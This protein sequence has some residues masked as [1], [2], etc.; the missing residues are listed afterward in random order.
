MADKPVTR[1]EA[2]DPSGKPATRHEAVPAQAKPVTRHEM[3]QGPGS[4]ATRHEEVP[5]ALRRFQLPAE[6]TSRYVYEGDLSSAGAQ[7]DVVLCRDRSSGEQVA[8][9]IY[10]PEMTAALESD[11]LASLAEADRA[12]V[13]PFRLESNRHQVWEVQEYF[14]LGS[15]EDAVRARGGGAQ[16]DGF[17]REVL[18][19][20]ALS[21]DHI[22]SRNIVHRDLKPQNILIRSLSP[23]DT[24]LA[25]FGLA[26]LGAMSRAVRSVAGTAH[27]TSPE[28][29]VGR[30]NKAND[31]WGLGIIV[32]ELLTGRH[33]FSGPDGHYLSDNEVRAAFF[34]HSWSYADVTSHRWRL[35]LDGLFAPGEHRWSW[36]Q[37]DAWLRGESPIAVP[38]TASATPQSSRRS[39][40]Y[41]FAAGE[42]HTPQELASA[43]RDNFMLARDHISGVKASDLISWLHSTSV[44]TAAD[45]LLVA[46][47][48][49]TAS[50]G[51]AV[52]ELQF[53]LDPD[54]PPVYQG[55]VLS[56]EAL[57]E[58]AKEALSGDTT[59]ADWI[60]NLRDSA[61]LTVMGR[62]SDNPTMSHADEL[63]NEWWRE[64][65]EILWR[66]AWREAAIQPFVEAAR[67]R[68]EGVL[69]GAA[70]NT[71]TH[72]D[73]SARASKALAEMPGGDSNAPGVNAVTSL[74]ATT[75]S[76]TA[77]TDALAMFVVP[78]WSAQE[79]LRRA[80][81]KR[82]ADEQERQR[83]EHAQAAAQAQARARA[84]TKA[85]ERAAAN[86]EKYRWLLG[87]GLAAALIAVLAA[88]LNGG[89]PG[90]EPVVAEP[91]VSTAEASVDP[92]AG[93]SAPKY[94]Q[95]FPEL[96]EYT[97]GSDTVSYSVLSAQG[98]NDIVL[99]ISSGLRMV[100]AMDREKNVEAYPL[101]ADP[102]GFVDL[103]VIDDLV[104]VSD[105]DDV[106]AYNGASGA[107]KWKQVRQSDYDL[108]VQDSKLYLAD[109]YGDAIGV[110]LDTGEPISTE[111]REYD[112]N[113]FPR[114]PHM[115]MYWQGDIECS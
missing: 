25:D 41:H 64:L 73:L 18:R 47:R 38:W 45:D 28:G 57:S 59:A 31:W 44:G 85:R 102:F 46:A 54:T 29:A 52:V 88:L 55:R 82:A 35:L 14:P 42:H 77:A 60:K 79:N 23:L 9:K 74:R 34:D 48:A 114:P 56:S 80:A 69:L 49:G 108:S 6:I 109:N 113:A 27:Y 40:A 12:H 99:A 104:I 96:S 95:A 50:P 98:G 71:Q 87:A 5:E 86:Q 21:L 62:Y 26:R 19:E 107:V 20:V 111:D 106:I 100:K 39:R 105:S 10:R 72:G 92:V 22:H 1:H 43:I 70:L 84:A 7:A 61:V 81:A 65:E 15:L 33:M 68:L 51:R 30:G 8:I 112:D 67:P 101:M 11:A 91:L 97:R 3:T 76:S 37:V 89:E 16:P 90:G 4:A 32:H 93:A 75:S 78:A 115:D 13:V 94:C 58:A 83:R 103:A 36:P 53:L 66:P 17:C 63:L 2:I 110:S 24:V